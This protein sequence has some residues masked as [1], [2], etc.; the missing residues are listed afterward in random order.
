M[1]R[2]L[3]KYYLKNI[4]NIV[5]VN[6]NLLYI[7]NMRNENKKRIGFAIKELRERDFMN[8]SEFAEKLGTTQSYLS[9]LER[10]DR[11]S[12]PMVKRVAEALSI[13]PLELLSYNGHNN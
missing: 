3:Y 6:K 13:E 8:Q 7:Y 5:V 2:I 4:L 12:L 10:S 1:Q 9:Q 11:I